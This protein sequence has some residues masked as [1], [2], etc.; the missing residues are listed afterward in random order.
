MPEN[1]PH[2]SAPSPGKLLVGRIVVVIFL[3]LVAGVLFGDFL[4]WA[5][6]GTPFLFSPRFQAMQTKFHGLE[7][8]LAVLFLGKAKELWKANRFWI[9]LVEFLVFLGAVVPIAG[10]LALLV[11][12]TAVRGI[13]VLSRPKII[14][15]EVVFVLIF[16]CK[17][18]IL[19]NLW[20]IVRPDFD[21]QETRR[22]VISK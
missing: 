2:P 17:W 8:A 12:L 5:V 22:I 6:A 13:G 3:L 9:L 21:P 14:L 19:S 20:K 1:A 4:V 7:S 15:L 10:I 18:N 11:R 16:S